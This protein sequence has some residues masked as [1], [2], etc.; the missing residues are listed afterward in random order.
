VQAFLHFLQL[1]EMPRL[2]CKSESKIAA[3]NTDLDEK[4]APWPACGFDPDWGGCQ[5]IRS[6]DIRGIERNCR[7]KE[8]RFRHFAVELTV[9]AMYRLSSRHLYT[10]ETCQGNATPCIGKLTDKVDALH[11]FEGNRH[12]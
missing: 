3:G 8:K 11:V 2:V 7:Q 4:T 12:G 6:P 9:S 5:R 1:E 10:A